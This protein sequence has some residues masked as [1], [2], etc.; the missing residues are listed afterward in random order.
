MSLWT[1]LDGKRKKIPINIL[2][3]VNC[4]SNEENINKRIIHQFTLF[5]DYAD[6]KLFNTENDSLITKKSFYL[7]SAL[8]FCFA[9]VYE[10]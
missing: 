10:L 6:F 7:H 5:Q 8:Y 3:K 2:S 4:T 1:N 9:V